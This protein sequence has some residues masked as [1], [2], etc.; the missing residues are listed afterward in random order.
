MRIRIRLQNPD[1]LLKPEMFTN[2]TISNIE[3]QQAICIPLSALVE[4]NSQTYVVL[5]NNDCDLQIAQVEVLQKTG[6]KA[7]MKSGIHA[8]QKLLT[9]NALLIYDEFTDNQK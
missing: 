8:G 6:E 5:Y 1:M 2:V 7:F 3:D 4:E 9:H